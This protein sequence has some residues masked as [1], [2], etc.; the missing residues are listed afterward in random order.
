ME[1]QLDRAVVVVPLRV[2]ATYGDDRFVSTDTIANVL[3]TYRK[4]L[5]LSDAEDAIVERLSSD[6]FAAMER[7]GRT[8]LEQVSWAIG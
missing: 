5:D 8:L 7:D 2:L 6:L 3:R 1:I 4:H